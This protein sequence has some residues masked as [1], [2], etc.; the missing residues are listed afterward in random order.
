MS[1]PRSTLSR[2][3]V[4]LNCNDYVFVTNLISILGGNVFFDQFSAT[5]INGKGDVRWCWAGWRTYNLQN[6]RTANS[7][8]FD[9]FWTKPV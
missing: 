6:L 4:Q 1:Q 5:F 9:W 7:T 2:I 8:A 3:S